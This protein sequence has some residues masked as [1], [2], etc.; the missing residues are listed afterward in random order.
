[1]GAAKKNKSKKRKGVVGFDEEMVKK[2]D[3][4]VILDQTFNNK[5]IDN[6]PSEGIRETVGMKQIQRRKKGIKNDAETNVSTMNNMESEVGEE[7]TRKKNR[8]Q[9]KK[10]KKSDT[11]CE[12]GSPSQ[13]GPEHKAPNKVNKKK[14]DAF[15]IENGA[16]DDVSPKKKRKEIENSV[17]Q[18]DND[19]DGTEP[20]VEKKESIRAQKRRKHAELLSQKKMKAELKMQQ[21]ALNYLSKWKHSRS[22]WKF[23]KL[24]Q[25]WLQ[26]NLYD[27]ANIPKEFWEVT[28]EYFAGS[29]G[30]TRDTIL[31][32][33]VKII[34]KEE[35]S[36]ESNDDE[37]YQMKL[38]RARDI[39]QYLQ[40]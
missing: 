25:I 18:E 8:K 39:I 34:E 33:A 31:K 6:P 23:E 27:E 28:V 30:S 4:K 16:T 36:E 12:D 35:Q 21:S 19:V 17:P 38:Q 11:D 29:K 9:N 14:H 15:N 22:D 10:V 20:I 1:M 3:A 32:E 2:E 37:D 26:Q 7:F 40:E 24:K 5:V 13:N